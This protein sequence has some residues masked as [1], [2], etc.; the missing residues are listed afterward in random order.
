[1]TTIY[2]VDDSPQV[3]LLAKA[4]HLDALT[5]MIAEA[6]DSGISVTTQSL[7][8]LAQQLAHEVNTLVLSVSRGSA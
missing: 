3:Q 1:M 8:E 2:T 4:A 7:L 6:D 5:T